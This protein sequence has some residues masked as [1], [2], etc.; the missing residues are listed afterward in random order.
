MSIFDFLIGNM[1]RHHYETF[2]IFGNDSFI[3]HLDHGRGFGKANHD[4]KSILA[5]LYQC[6]FIHITTFYR[7]LQLQLNP[8][9]L[10][11]MMRCSM[12]KDPLNPILLD[13]HLEALDRRLEAV[14]RVLRDC[15]QTHGTDQVF[16]YDMDFDEASDIYS[17]SVKLFEKDVN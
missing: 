8:M 3:V 9:K 13:P 14:L 5:P 16:F 10:S 2:K 17:E 12:Y 6:C 4:E 1:D 7:L 15:F 11:T